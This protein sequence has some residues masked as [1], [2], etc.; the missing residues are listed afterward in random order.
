MRTRGH[1]KLERGK[2]MGEE[3][4]KE[5]HV[6]IRVKEGEGRGHKTRDK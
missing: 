2:Y 3:G 5:G 1:E 6:K 4:K